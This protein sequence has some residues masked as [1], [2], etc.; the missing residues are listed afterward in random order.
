[1]S[2]TLHLGVIELPYSYGDTSMTTG[3]VA[4][5]LEGKYHIM[6]QWYTHRE[7]K[8]ADDLTEGMTD[9]LEA[10]LM[11]A[12]PTL[13]PFGSA[14]SK[15]EQ[16]FRTFLDSKEIESYGIF[17]VPTQAALKGVSHRFKKPYAKRGPRP[18]FIDSGLYQSAFRAWVD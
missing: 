17:G 13:D 14:T 1:M 4:E 11:G 2:L 16:D 15:M 7:Q 8:V 10:L 6:E 12:P 5:I 3:D 9:A 18:S